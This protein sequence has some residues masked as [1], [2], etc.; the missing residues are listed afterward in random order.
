MAQF[1]SLTIDDTGYLKL[2][3]GTEAQ[4]T[5]SVPIGSLRYNS[6]SG[7]LDASL[8]TNGWG[9]IE[10]IYPKQ[11]SV[12]P[13]AT[14]VN[15]G[16]NLG[17]NV[18]TANVADNTTLYWTLTNSS[19]FTV[20]SG[21]FT[22]TNNSGS[23][24]VTPTADMVTEGAET[25]TVS[26]R[27]DSTSGTIVA[28]SLLTTINDTSLSPSYS[29][30]AT[31]T[32]VAEGSAFTVNVTTTN[33]TDGTALYYTLSGTGITSSDIVGGATS[34]SLTITSNAGSVA[35]TIRDDYTSE[36]TETLTF[37]LRSGSTS[38][39]IVATTNITITDSGNVFTPTT[40]T[41]S[42][43]GTYTY[44]A[45][46]GSYTIKMW[47]GAGGGA[48]KYQSGGGAGATLSYTTIS[49]AQTWTVYVANTG[50]GA[51]GSADSGNNVRGA[52]GSGYG[53]GGNGAGPASNSGVWC[54]GGGGGSSAVTGTPLGTI[55]AAGGGGA[56][57]DIG[58]SGGAGG[59]GGGGAGSGPAGTGG[60]GGNGSGGGGGATYPN[61]AQPSAGSGGTNVA[62]S[63]GSSY[64]GS[65]TS[66]GNT[67]D[68][69]YISGKGTPGNSGLVVILHT[70]IG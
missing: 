65:G 5:E 19:D 56:A 45:N 26:I 9:N 18:Y 40:T 15:E 48:P 43:A 33:I 42:T 69:N 8:V 23:F 6:T 21:S 31:P 54:G 68:A 24:S 46:P 53:A 4:R 50:G 60:S 20:S 62:G 70:G 38:G 35:I 36:S 29:I 2:P 11:Y 58:P 13:G 51:S 16:Q 25:F 28:T 55:I 7:G 37:E 66:T 12:V 39:T 22:I 64:N 3:T 59:A 57:G 44:N 32:T 10:A 30:S 14:S 1:T 27:T 47:G 52:G 63:G 34:G 41:Y 17:I 61:Q 49:S 67:G